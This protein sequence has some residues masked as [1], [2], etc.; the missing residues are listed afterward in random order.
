MKQNWFQYSWYNIG[1]SYLT[2]AL[3]S[4]FWFLINLSKYYTWYSFMVSEVVKLERWRVTLSYHR[5]SHWYYKIAPIQQ[6]TGVNLKNHGAIM[7]WQRVCRR[8]RWTFA[9]LLS[10]ASLE[11]KELNDIK[12]TKLTIQM[13]YLILPK[14]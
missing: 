5:R 7:N 8:S 14:W 12:A 2:L 9:W 6:Q 11:M 10:S 4:L 1:R 3:N 13:T